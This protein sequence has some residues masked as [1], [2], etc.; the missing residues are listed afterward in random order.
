MDNQNL[1]IISV[2]DDQNCAGKHCPTVYRSDD[3]RVFVQGRR[4]DPGTWKSVVK[5]GDEDLVEVPADLL[6]NL[7][8]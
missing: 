3:G 8:L 4:V 2:D 7:D 6:K 1:T 5:S